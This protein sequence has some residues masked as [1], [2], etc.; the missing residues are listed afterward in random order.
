MLIQS[1]YNSGCV[2]HIILD[3]WGNWSFGLMLVVLDDELLN[4]QNHYTPRLGLSHSKFS[5]QIIQVEVFLLEVRPGLSRLYWQFD[6]LLL[7]DCEWASNWLK[8]CLK[9]LRTNVRHVKLCAIYFRRR[10]RKYDLFMTVEE[11][12]VL[13]GQLYGCPSQCCQAVALK[14]KHLL[15]FQEEQLKDDQS[16]L[17]YGTGSMEMWTIFLEVLQSKSQPDSS[18]GNNAYLCAIS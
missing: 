1:M 5:Q 8:Q 13:C 7:W 2:L 3:S 4:H 12:L 16:L 17:I 15:V 9:D 11:N 14:V 6:P 18:S 10:R